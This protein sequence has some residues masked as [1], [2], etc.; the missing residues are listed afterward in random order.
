[1]IHNWLLG[2]S[3]DEIASD[4]GIST[5]TVYNINKAFF[6]SLIGYD[7]EAISD[8]VAQVRKENLTVKQFAFGYR[9]QTIL[10]NLG[11][12]YDEK[13]PTFLKDTYRLCTR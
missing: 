5:V 6:D 13:L 9:I 4:L 7:I 10:G 12:C 1:M 11:I 8:F 2:N 3:S